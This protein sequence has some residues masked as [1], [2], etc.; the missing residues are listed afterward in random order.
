MGTMA[1]RITSLAIVYSTIYSGA[2]Q[3]KHQSS[4]SLAF[5][6][7]IHRG[8]VNFLHK[9]PV[10]WKMFPFEIRHHAWYSKRCCSSEK[11]P[12]F[13]HNIRVSQQLD[14]PR[15]CKV[16]PDFIIVN[17]IVKKEFSKIKL[18]AH[19]IFG[20]CVSE[21]VTVQ[22]KCRTKKYPSTKNICMQRY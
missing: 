18:W 7:G 10:T 14:C 11:K 4:A 2:D 19:S 9:W 20:K 16:G 15:R 3:R 6:R 21:L 12:R 17:K 5:V 13:D 22:Q 1:S 8:L